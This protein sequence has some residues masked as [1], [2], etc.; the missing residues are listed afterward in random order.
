MKKHN[1]FEIEAQLKK[2]LLRL[3]GMQSKRIDRSI[4]L[5]IAAL[6]IYI[7]SNSISSLLDSE[8][9]VIIIESLIN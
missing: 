3:K 8:G 1:R 2:G 9:I 7:I 6:A 4:S 5:L